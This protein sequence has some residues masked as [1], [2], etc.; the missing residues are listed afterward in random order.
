MLTHSQ[1]GELIYHFISKVFNKE[2]VSQ[3][4]DFIQAFY[5]KTFYKNFENSFSASL[6]FRLI[7]KY[8][9]LR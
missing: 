9:I 7:K 3:A 6:D 5:F 2:Y 8:S 4:L 1:K